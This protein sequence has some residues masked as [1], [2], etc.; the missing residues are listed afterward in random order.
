MTKKQNRFGPPPPLSSGGGSGGAFFP[1][2]DGLQI[3]FGA[4]YHEMVLSSPEHKGS[5]NFELLSCELFQSKKRSYY[6]G[7]NKSPGRFALL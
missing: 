3:F 6:I 4:L 2:L 5:G 7:K 1:T